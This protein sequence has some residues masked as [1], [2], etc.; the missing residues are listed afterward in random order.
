[1]ERIFDQQ[2][3][4]RSDKA[5]DNDSDG[6]DASFAEHAL[7]GMTGAGVL[8]SYAAGPLVL[9]ASEVARACA[10]AV[11]DVCAPRLFARPEAKR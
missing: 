9:V 4:P 5:P 6:P 11:S 1:M 10:S 7:S 8:T 2:W 3:E